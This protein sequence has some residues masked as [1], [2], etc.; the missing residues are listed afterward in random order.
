MDALPSHTSGKTQP[1]DTVLFVA[2]ENSLNKSVSSCSGFNDRYTINLFGMC[3]IMREAYENSFTKSS[4]Q[5]SFRRAG[6]W[7][8]NAKCLIG[9]PR[10]ASAAADAPILTIDMLEKRFEERRKDVREM[11]LLCDA[12]TLK[13]G[14]VDTANGCV[15]TA[16]RVMELVKKKKEG[17]ERKRIIEEK[18]R[19]LHEMKSTKRLQK[20]KAEC[21]KIRHAQNKYRAWMSGVPVCESEGK[22]ASV[23]RRE[24]GRSFI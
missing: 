22:H 11:V 15:T 24:G 14:Y 8:L 3:K 23:M 12:E 6:L 9:E 4:I 2:F 16:G 17:D 19:L 1:V 21:A 7:P 5:A 10:P 18:G 13:C 20:A